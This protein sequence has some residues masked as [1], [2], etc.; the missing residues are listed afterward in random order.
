MSKNFSDLGIQEDLV[1]GI[2]SMGITTPTAIQEQAIP[3]ILAG[4]DVLGIAQTG[5]GKTAAF[6]LPIIQ[7]ITAR[8][9]RKH[10]SALIIVPT[11]ELATQIDQAIQAYGYFTDIS[12]IPIYG[13]G[14]GKIF[15]QERH[16]LESGADIVVATPGR[17]I[18]TSI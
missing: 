10:S 11:R 14:D 13:G 12:S 8:T 9:D 3:A 4:N 2:D 7:K 6:L 1:Q 17:L 18:C 5:T 15:N 16:A